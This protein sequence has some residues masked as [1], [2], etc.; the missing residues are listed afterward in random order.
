MALVLEILISRPDTTLNWLSSL[1]VNAVRVPLRKTV[2]SSAYM[3]VLI[4]WF[5]NV[6]PLMRL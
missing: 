4:L 5:L 2:V 3:V 1:F 6:V